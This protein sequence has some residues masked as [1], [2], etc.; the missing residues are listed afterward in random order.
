MVKCQAGAAPPCVSF[1]SVPFGFISVSFC[2]VLEMPG[3]MGP[4]CVVRVPFVSFCEVLVM[5]GRVG[6]RVSFGVSACVRCAV[7]FVRSFA[8]EQARRKQS[9][10]GRS[11]ARA[12]CPWQVT[13]R[14]DATRRD[15]RRLQVRST[16]HTRVWFRAA[17]HCRPCK[18]CSEVAFKFY[19]PHRAALFCVPVSIRFDSY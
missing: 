3:R 9:W 14:G 7:G 10:G 11:F 19:V 17:I 15:Q 6:P 2:K 12:R 4:L 18:Q 1:R 8:A 16:R 5:P 13:Q